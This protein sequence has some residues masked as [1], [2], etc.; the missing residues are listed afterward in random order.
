MAAL[1]MVPN[2]CKQRIETI[3]SGIN[4]GINLEYSQ[5]ELKKRI[6]N[7]TIEIARIIEL[8]KRIE[9]VSDVSKKLYRTYIKL[10]ETDLINNLAHM[11]DVQEKEVNFFDRNFTPNGHLMRKNNNFGS[12]ITSSD[13]LKAINTYLR[14]TLKSL[15]QTLGN[16]ENENVDLRRFTRTFVIGARGNLRRLKDKNILELVQGDYEVTPILVKNTSEKSMSR[17][18]NDYVLFAGK[19]HNNSVT[20]WHLGVSDELLHT[21]KL[22]HLTPY[23]GSKIHDIVTRVRTNR[24]SIIDAINVAHANTGH[25]N[26]THASLLEKILTLNYLNIRWKNSTDLSK[27]DQFAKAINDLKTLTIPNFEKTSVNS[28]SRQLVSSLKLKNMLEYLEKQNVKSK[29]R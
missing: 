29:E 27:K 25:V 12:N 6:E 2:T 13:R 7:A 18:G 1:V 21:K 10:L 24:E 28:D 5:N 15:D 23:D 11:Y 4:P 9:K 3:Y 19:G 26:Y 22:S 20:C 8:Q 17:A 14:N 16:Q